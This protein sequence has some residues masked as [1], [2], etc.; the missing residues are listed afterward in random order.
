MTNKTL[1]VVG[2]AA[3]LAMG[4]LHVQ[5]AQAQLRAGSYVANFARA[6]DECVSGNAVTV[7]NPGGIEGCPAANVTTD[8]AAGW[9]T[10]RLR[11][12]ATARRGTI[13][14]LRKI[15]PSSVVR[16]R[17]RCV[18]ATSPRMYAVG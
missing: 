6:Y 9:K 10:A 4:A 2:A 13:I 7:V 11:L 8:S 18:A 14:N 15:R 5:V 3:I 16:P 17:G 1:T 12:M